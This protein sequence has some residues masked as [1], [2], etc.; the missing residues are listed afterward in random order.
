MEHIGA[1]CVSPMH[2]SPGRAARIVL[3]K[4]VVSAAEVDRSVRIVHPVVRR[5]EMVLGPQRVG[6]QFLAQ[7][8]IARIATGEERAAPKRTDSSA[9]HLQEGSASGH[10]FTVTPM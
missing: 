2:V 5:Q 7:D 1:C 8:G 4:H 3:V 9:G 10:E 6:R